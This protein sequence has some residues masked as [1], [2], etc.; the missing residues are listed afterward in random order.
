MLNS[1]SKGNRDDIVRGFVQISGAVA[2]LQIEGAVENAGLLEDGA[3]DTLMESAPDSDGSWIKEASE[4][5]D[6]SQE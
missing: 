5:Q 1:Y 2:G 3:L 6:E 4:E